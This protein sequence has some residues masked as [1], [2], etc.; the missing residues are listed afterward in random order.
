MCI[1]SVVTGGYGSPTVL[2]ELGWTGVV[3][4][5]PPS[6]LKPPSIYPQ[7]PSRGHQQS[8]DPA[9]QQ[10]QR[11][12][13]PPEEAVSSPPS[14]PEIK[15]NK[16]MSF[17]ANS[18]RDDDDSVTGSPSLK[19]PPGDERGQEEGSQSNPNNPH[20]PP[21]N[22]VSSSVRTETSGGY[23]HEH[24]THAAAHETSIHTH[25]GF[26]HS[27]QLRNERGIGE[28]VSSS[29]LTYD[30]HSSNMITTSTRGSHQNKSSSHRRRSGRNRASHHYNHH[31]SHHRN[32]RHT[33][34][35][36]HG[37]QQH[38]KRSNT[39]QGVYANNHALKLNQI[40]RPRPRT[41]EIGNPKNPYI[42]IYI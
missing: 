9:A 32:Q 14:S 7:H 31:K 24:E 12:L 28:Y 4:S 37:Q 39:S 2:H 35:S 3:P 27:Q 41:A 29:Y 15:H 6:V 30:R 21:G 38:V 25:A 23:T 22:H 1:C 18:K 20:N 40:S 26:E 17:P 36:A 10:Q 13:M 11:L 5:L 34:G 33:G 8:S 42:Y 19:S 16:N